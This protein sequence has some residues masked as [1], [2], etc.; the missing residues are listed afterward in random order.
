MLRLPEADLRHR[1]KQIDQGVPSA[2]ARQVGFLMA[3][4]SSGP[5]LTERRVSE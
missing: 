5:D 1:R 3:V 2:A 4:R